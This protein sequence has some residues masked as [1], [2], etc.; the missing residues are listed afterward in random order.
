M[1]GNLKLVYLLFWYIL[2]SFLSAVVDSLAPLSVWWWLA[3]VSTIATWYMFLI[4]AMKNYRE[5]S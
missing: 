3:A 2:G 4:V 5:D 1:T